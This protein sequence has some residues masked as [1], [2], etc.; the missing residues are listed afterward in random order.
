[1]KQLSPYELASDFSTTEEG[2]EEGVGNWMMGW[3][4]ECMVKE[5]IACPEIGYSVS[6]AKYASIEEWEKATGKVWW[7]EYAP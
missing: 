1:M 3:N 7:D 2:D 5:R 6:E 4:R